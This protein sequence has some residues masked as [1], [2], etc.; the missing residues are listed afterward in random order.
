[1]QKVQT[2][3]NVSLPLL[4]AIDTGGTFTDFFI[5]KLNKNKPSYRIHKVLS[6][7]RDPSQA[8]LTGLKDLGLKDNFELIHGSTVATNAFLEGKGAR[9]VLVTTE[10]FEDILE[11]GRQNRPQLYS[12]H[13]TREQPIVPAKRRLGIAERIHAN[14]KIS[15]GFEKKKL[16]ELKNKIKKLNPESVAVCLINAYAN[17]THEKKT[18]EVLRVLKVPLSLSS[19]VCP[20]YREFE[21]TSTTCLNAYV[22][23]VMTHYLTKLQKKL[24]GKNSGKTSVQVQVM[25]SNGGTLTLK[26]ASTQAVRTLLSGP[27]GGALGAATIAKL[28]G[29]SQAI[30]LDMGGTSTDLSLIDG[31]VEYTSETKLQ[32]LPIKTPM[33]RIDTIGAGGGSLAWVDAGGALRVGPQSAGAAPGPICYGSGGKQVTITDAHVFLG[34]LPAQ[35]FLGGRMKLQ[36]EKIRA[37]LKKL[38]RQLKLSSEETAQGILTV[39]NHHMARALRVLSLER[40]YD[41]RQF[42][43]IP[44]GGAGALHACELAELLNIPQVLVP[45][46]PGILSAYGMAH[47]GWRRDF[48]ETLLWPEEKVTYLKLKKEVQKLIGKAYR[49]ARS[50]G[51]SPKKLLSEASVDL[52]YQ[53][54]SFELNVPLTKN[55]AAAFERKHKAHYGFCHKKPLEIVNLRLTVYAARFLKKFSATVPTEKKLKAFGK[56]PLYFEGKTYS[57]KL[58]K[59]EDLYPGHKIK[60]PAVITE[61]SAT[62]FVPPN[63]SL[64]LDTQENLI[65]RK[66]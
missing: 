13:P 3:S 1:M 56:S 5:L 14:G 48:V 7:P 54:Q 57:A 16:R 23:P 25:Q 66:L 10:G 58:F 17:S 55:Y 35:H 64:K 32:G 50:A 29:V 63:W 34:R 11:I 20:E 43:L 40:G 21:R 42:T 22:T 52:R 4:I 9:V 51:L 39:A 18:A 46:N 49:Q 37:P 41:P 45:Q 62:T 31:Q 38:S 26:E 33:I 28:A 36:A 15:Q 19:E 61:L 60:G 24:V 44:F 2:V 53:G 30:S 12:L 27:A 6:T 8:I 47:A 59:R 65:L